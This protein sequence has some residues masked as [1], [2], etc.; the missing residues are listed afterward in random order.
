MINEDIIRLLD[1]I[2]YDRNLT[3]NRYLNPVEVHKELARLSD[4]FKQEEIGKSVDGNAIRKIIWGSGSTRVMMWSQMHGNESTT[5]RALINLLFLIDDNPSYLNDLYEN[6]QLIIIPIVNPDG[7][8]SYERFNANQVD[9]NRDAINLSQPESK[10]LMNCFESYQPDFCLNLHDQRS[11]YGVDNNFACLSFLAPS[12]NK[13]QSI[14]PNR[15]KSMSLIAETTGFLSNNGLKGNIGRYDETYNKNCFG[16]FFQNRGTPTILV[17]AGQLQ[18]DYNRDIAAYYSTQ[19][20]LFLLKSISNKDLTD[21]LVR[22]YYKIPMNEKVFTDLLIKNVKINNGFFH[23]AIMYE[24]KVYK[25]KLMYLLKVENILNGIKA[26]HRIIDADGY[27]L[28]GKTGN[29]IKQL[30]VGEYLSGLR[31]NSVNFSLF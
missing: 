18:L 31:V 2:N 29:K 26:S 13:E 20:I 28:E 27:Y 11:I 21:K 6:L 4:V 14:N 5:T 19:G 22:K 12:Y 1:K 8:L 30:A 10:L 23:I 24:M 15:E 7:A 25:S 16:D 3:K 17:E 9:L